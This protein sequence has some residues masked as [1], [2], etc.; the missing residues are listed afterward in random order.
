ML[1]S[2]I[3]ISNYITGNNFLSSPH[4]CQSYY[5][6]SNWSGNLNL[7]VCFCGKFKFCLKYVIVSV[8]NLNSTSSTRSGHYHH[9]RNGENF[10]C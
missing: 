9:A 10:E 2:W 5:A 4:C 7:E 6:G 8:A 3:L 1:V